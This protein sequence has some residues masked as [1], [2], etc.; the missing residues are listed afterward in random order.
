MNEV[1]RLLHKQRVLQSEYEQRIG[2]H[3]T[4]I[5]STFLVN[6]EVVMKR[7]VVTAAILIMLQV[8]AL[9][10]LRIQLLSGLADLEGKAGRK[11]QKVQKTMISELSEVGNLIA[12]KQQQAKTWESLRIPVEPA[13]LN[14]AQDL[15]ES[16][17]HVISENDRAAVKGF[18]EWFEAGYLKFSERVGG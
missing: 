2:Q 5:R 11:V 17:K 16:L 12:L 15:L 3:E 9:N 10:E 8:I 13:D 7:T 4:A 14:V 1:N 18:I 6:P